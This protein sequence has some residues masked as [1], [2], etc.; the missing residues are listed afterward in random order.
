MT[1]N[2]IPAV[3]Q[4]RKLSILFALASSKAAALCGLAK[5]E[6]AGRKAKLLDCIEEPGEFEIG[7]NSEGDNFGDEKDSR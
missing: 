4:G 5:N 2:E 6:D 1:G 7:C 3:T